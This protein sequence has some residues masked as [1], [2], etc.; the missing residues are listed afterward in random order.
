M[1]IAPPNTQATCNSVSERANAD[2]RTSSG[3]S[4]WISASRESFRRALREPRDRRQTGRR[5]GPEEYG[6]GDR[7]PQHTRDDR[8]DDD[9][10]GARFQ[11]GPDRRAERVA[12]ARRDAHYPERDGRALAGERVL[13][14]EEGEEEDQEAGEAAQGGVG[15]WAWVTAVPTVRSPAAGHLSLMRCGPCRCSSSA[16]AAPV[17]A[18][19]QVDLGRQ[20][21]R[22]ERARDEDDEGAVERIA[23]AEGLQ[24]RPIGAAT[25]P[26]A[27]SA[28]VTREFAFTR[29]NRGGNSLGTT[30]LRTTP[31]DLD[32]TSTPSAAGSAPGCRSPP[33][34][35]AAARAWPGRTSRPP[36]RPGGRAA[37]G[38]EAG[39]SPGRGR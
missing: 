19:G 15:A 26:V 39:R 30:A 4:R 33:R 8:H 21:E 10:R 11:P 35:T 34:P 32:A 5:D 6:G 17:L 1:P 16:T 18:L 36:S 20:R 38:P 3:T 37:D 25:P 9:L 2:V 27:R 28:R 24:P 13:A 23:R 22:A 31:Y 12:R 7:G 29:E 14:D